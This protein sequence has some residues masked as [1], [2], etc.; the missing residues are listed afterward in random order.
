MKPVIAS[1]YLLKSL[2]DSYDGKVEEI[3]NRSYLTEQTKHLERMI[4]TYYIQSKDPM[5][6]TRHRAR[7][8]DLEQNA[9]GLLNG[10]KFSMAFML[11]KDGD[12]K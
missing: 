6:S 7:A 5:L 9:M 4:T 2:L 11:H 1:K 12:L 8:R 3:K 10:I